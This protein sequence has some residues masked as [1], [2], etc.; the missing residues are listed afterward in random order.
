LL[1][2]EN[3]PAASLAAPEV[4]WLSTTGFSLSLLNFLMLK[5]KPTG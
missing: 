4:L 1:Q 3:D 5:R 2:A